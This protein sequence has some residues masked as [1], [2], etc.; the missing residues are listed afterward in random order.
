MPEPRCPA[1][2]KPVEARFA[3][4]CSARCQQVDLGRWLKGDYVIPAAP[5]EGERE[6]TDPQS[7]GDSA[8][9]EAQ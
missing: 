6:R 7:G 2:G 9:D 5:A 1:C 4:F 3:P 8:D